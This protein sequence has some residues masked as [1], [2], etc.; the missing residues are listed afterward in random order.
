MH[1]CLECNK[2][3]GQAGKLKRHMVTHTQ[4]RAYN[5]KSEA[6]HGNPQQEKGLQLRSMQ[7]IFWSFSTSEKAHDDPQ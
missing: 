7:E 4:E 1:I 2:S 5:W 6:A 3:F